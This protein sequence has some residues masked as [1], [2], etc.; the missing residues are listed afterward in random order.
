MTTL[1]TQYTG[2]RQT[3]QKIQHKKLKRWAIRTT[4]KNQG[5]TLKNT[6]EQIVKSP[7]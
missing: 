5:W 3:K 6:N 1:G 2:G 7:T 4:T